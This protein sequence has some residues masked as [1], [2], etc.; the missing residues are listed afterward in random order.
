[1]S[2]I[3][4]IQILFLIFVFFAGSRAFLRLKEGNLSIGSFLF[5][6]ALWTLAIV[7]IIEPEF[8]TYVARLIGI[9]RGTDVVIYLSIILMFYLLFR[10]NVMIEDLKHE[11]SKL[12][13]QLAIKNTSKKQ[14][15]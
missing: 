7:S 4:P 12:T 1:M 5:W 11:V 2:N 8:T 15:K 9:G 6:F 10:T 3:V 13:T 14:R